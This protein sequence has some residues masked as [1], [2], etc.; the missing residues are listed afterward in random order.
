MKKNIKKPIIQNLNRKAPLK[1]TLKIPKPKQRGQG[2][3]EYIIL[4]AI[5]AIASLGIVRALGHVTS[6]QLANITLSLQGKSARK[7]K[8]QKV[9]R[10][11]YSK[12]DLSNFTT[13]SSKDAND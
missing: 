2:L 11:L 6:T 9:G 12:K 13:N 10:S 7:I 8:S 4:V 1:R 5:I 3:V